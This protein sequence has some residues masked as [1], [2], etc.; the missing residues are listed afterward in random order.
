MMLRILSVGVLLAA[1]AAAT[2][3]KA[4]QATAPAVTI[5]QVPGPRR[6]DDDDRRERIMGTV[7]GAPD[8]AR[9]VLW[10]RTDRWWVQPFREPTDVGGPYTFI[11]DGRWQNDTHLGTEYAALLVTADYGDIAYKGGLKLPQPE[12]LELPEVGGKVL[13][14]TIVRAA[15]APDPAP[16]AVSISITEVPR[17]GGTDEEM[18]HIGGTVSGV[19]SERASVVI[20]ART[21]EWRVQ[22]IA[23]NRT[24]DWP[25]G[26]FTTIDSKGRWQNDTNLG[27]EY[28]AVVV[29]EGYEGLPA[30]TPRLPEVG[31]AIWALA[32]AK[33]VPVKPAEG[34]EKIRV[35]I[36]TVPKTGR[37]DQPMEVIAGSI[38]GA[39]SGARIVLFAH[40]KDMWRIQPFKE[41]TRAAPDG[42]YTPVKGGKWSNSTHLG[43]EYAALVVTPDYK[44][45]TATRSLPPVGGGVLAVVSVKGR[46]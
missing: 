46:P 18:A 10:A 40:A 30:A 45:P 33:G 19:Q 14:R 12:L 28:A 43:L 7:T 9:V 37:G 24:P 20:F 39:P 44:P 4:E 21:N 42:S 23:G 2:P 26:R 27:E 35:S 1:F 13:A 34:A 3:S 41:P 32:V 16:G 31:G 11:E 8:G 15:V 29:R 38:E 17:P 22:P 6:G 25:G 36:T 5:T